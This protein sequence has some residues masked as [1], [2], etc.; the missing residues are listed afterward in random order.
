LTAYPEIAP[1][2]APGKEAAKKPQKARVEFLNCKGFSYKV[3]L[4][5]WECGSRGLDADFWRECLQLHIG[6]T[7]CPEWNGVEELHVA[8]GESFRFWIFPKATFSDEQFRTRVNLGNLGTVHLLING[9]EV[10]VKIG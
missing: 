2:P 3:K 5:G 8:P 6:T 7:W 1:P 4:I 9:Q 10:A